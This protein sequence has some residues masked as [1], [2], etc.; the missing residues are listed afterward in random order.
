MS[1]QEVTSVKSVSLKA[2]KGQKDRR[3][4]SI[5]SFTKG[6]HILHGM[7]FLFIVRTLGVAFWGLHQTVEN[8]EAVVHNEE[9][10]EQLLELFVE[11]KVAEDDQREFL[12]TQSPSFLQAYTA[13]AAKAKI[14]IGTLEYL[15]VGP[16]EF[17]FRLLFG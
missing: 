4:V 2:V 6:S 10:S 12:L 17:F 15:Y 11:I 1:E 14:R 13:T 5:L 3:Q 16:Q 7:T 8:F 9:N